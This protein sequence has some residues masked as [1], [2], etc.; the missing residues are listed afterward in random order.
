LDYN[1]YESVILDSGAITHVSNSCEQFKY[2]TPASE[3]DLLYSENTII[4]IKGFS[5]IDVNVQTPDGPRI[6]EL[7][8]IALI[9]SFY[10]SVVLLNQLKAKGVN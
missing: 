7:Q 8:N 6:I 2:L 5:P 3:D 4:L 1:L 10:T 9:L